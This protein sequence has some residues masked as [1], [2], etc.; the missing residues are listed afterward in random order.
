MAYYED[1]T[2][3]NY[4]HYCTKELN[5]GWL[6]KGQPF[7]IGKVPEGFLEKLQTYLT[8]D[9][10]VFH[11]MGDHDC[12]FCNKR[13]SASCEIRT[14]SIDGTV[15]AA[16]ELIKHYIESHGYLPPQEFIDS[17][18]NG[19]NPGSKEYSDIINKLPENWEK[20]RPDINDKDYEEKMIECMV[21]NLSK[22]VDSKI[23]SEI[24]EENKDFKKF[25]QAY[26]SIMPSVYAVNLETKNK[27]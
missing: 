10:T 11:Y 17:V 3:Y 5:V 14:V 13:E 25:I 4:S 21:D 20:R 2:P 24:L 27:K 7:T 6:Q 12:E 1:L 9:F 19:I 23:I 16:P 18:M 26:N 15:Y 8:S 22:E